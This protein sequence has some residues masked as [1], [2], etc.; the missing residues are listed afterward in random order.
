MFQTHVKSFMMLVHAF[1]SRCYVLLLLF[2]CC[3]AY[4]NFLNDLLTWNIKL[5]F[6]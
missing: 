1:G 3:G 4:E 6:F 5:L 2:I